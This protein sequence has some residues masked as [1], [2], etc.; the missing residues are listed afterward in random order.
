MV[1]EKE[2]EH[3]NNGVTTESDI[4]PDNSDEDNDSPLVMTTVTV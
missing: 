3:L 1:D 2:W 4:C